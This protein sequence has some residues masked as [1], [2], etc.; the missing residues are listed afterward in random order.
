MVKILMV[1]VVGAAIA[2]VASAVGMFIGNGFA[3][4]VLWLHKK[5]INNYN[6]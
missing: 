3:H 6:K 1:I 5:Q 4:F 2:L